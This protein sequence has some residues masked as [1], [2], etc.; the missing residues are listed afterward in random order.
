MGIKEFAQ[1]GGAVRLGLWLGKHLSLASGRRLAVCVGRLLALRQSSRMVRAIKANQWIV[2]GKS[3]DSEALKRRSRAVL[4]HIVVSLF[5]YFYYYQHV[6]ECKQKITLSPAIKQMLHEA[7]VEKKPTIILGPHIGN[8]DL[9][10]MMMV[11]FGLPAYALSYPHPNNAYKMQ[12]KLRIDA[13]MKIAPISFSTFRQA[14]QAIN[15]GYCL[16]TGIDRPLENSQ[17]TKYMPAFFGIPASV[18]TFYVRLALDTGTP[19]RVACGFSKSDHSFYY[20]CSAPIQ[21]EKADDLHTEIV[22]N[23]E[24]VMLAAEKFIEQESVQWAMFYP[25]WPEALEQIKDLS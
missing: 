19:V 9:F 16:V 17:D 21:L 3:L 1:D 20:D 5:E 8:F 15:D 11:K 2:S 25:V 24:K 22:G 10:G 4:E 12:N 18:P 14:K 7:V 23:A 6:E 13:G